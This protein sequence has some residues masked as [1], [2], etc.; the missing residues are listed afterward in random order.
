MTN[1]ELRK[2]W[3]GRVAAFKASG[4]STKDWCADHDLKIN[5]LRYWLRKLK[6]IDDSTVKQPQWVSVEV[7][8]LKTDSHDK[9]LPIKVGK[10]TIEVSPGFDPE[11]LSD[12]VRTLADL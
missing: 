12:V 6:T 9:A 3:E 7:G 4:K 5:Q 1:A 2:V 11:L 8:G 10:A